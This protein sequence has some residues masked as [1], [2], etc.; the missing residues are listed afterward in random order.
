MLQATKGIVF[1]HLNYAESSVIV[2]IYT[3]AYGLQSYMVKGVRSRKSKTR[4]ALFQPLTLLDLVV[5]HKEGK[6]LQH[7]REIRVEYAYHSIP[8]NLVKRSLLFFL[9][10]LLVKSIREETA[11]QPLFNWI[12][13]AL[14][15][16]DLSDSNMVN[17]HLVFMMQLT[18][19]LG[20]YPKN[21]LSSATVY[22]DLQEGQFVSHPPAHPNYTEDL[23]SNQLLAIHTATFEESGNLTITNKERR[24]LVETLVTYY[25]FHLPNF[26]ELKSLEVLKTIL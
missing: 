26:G 19:F 17:F 4:P 6:Q 15:W 20:F 2:K 9:D 22:F 23:L 13:N 7:I 12:I 1:Q 21:N 10:E 8:V 3:E 5:Y 16:L 14:K 18:R 24:K 25:R 11:N